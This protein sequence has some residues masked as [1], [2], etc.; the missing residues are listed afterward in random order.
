MT[1]TNFK[2]AIAALLAFVWLAF[3]STNGKSP[4][5][6]TGTTQTQPAKTAP[7]TIDEESK[8]VKC[9]AAKAQFTDAAGQARFS[10]KFLH[11]AVARLKKADKAEKAH[12]REVVEM[13]RAVALKHYEQ[14]YKL[15]KKVRSI[16]N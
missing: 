9:K 13:A 3:V 11:I 6:P 1:K 4:S 8:S 10:I 5:K 14:A 16:C 2:F 7:V 15:S 12:H